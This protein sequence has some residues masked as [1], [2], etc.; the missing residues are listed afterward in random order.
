M[1]WKW[2]RREGGKMDIRT[3]RR[4]LDS[5][6]ERSP[7]IESPPGKAIMGSQDHRR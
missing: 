4:D 3:L 5:R 6:S 1:D 2:N 7:R